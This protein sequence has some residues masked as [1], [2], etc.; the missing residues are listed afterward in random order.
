MVTLPPGVLPHHSWQQLAAGGGSDRNPLLFAYLLVC[1]EARGPA[2]PRRPRRAR[3]ER[4]SLSPA[5]VTYLFRDS[6]KKNSP[7]SS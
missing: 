6:A 2:N 4:L 7:Q 3:Q 1:I 5:S